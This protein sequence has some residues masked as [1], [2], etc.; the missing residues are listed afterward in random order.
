MGG[1]LRA[2]LKEEQMTTIS[3]QGVHHFTLTVT[4]KERSLDFYTS[5]LDFQ[6]VVDLGFRYI[7]S[8]GS[9]LMSV[10]TAPDESRAIVDDR[11]DEN[12]VGLDHLSF[13]VATLSDLE[14]R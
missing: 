7:L 2:F 1:N 6:M 5:V 11:F 8:N 12:R 10:G 4:D 13:S 3:V 14:R 9:V